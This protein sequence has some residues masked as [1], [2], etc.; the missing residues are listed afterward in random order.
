MRETPRAVEVVAVVASAV[1]K[2]RHAVRSEGSLV[3]AESP[4]GTERMGWVARGRAGLVRNPN[5]EVRS[6]K[7]RLSAPTISIFGRPFPRSLRACVILRS[8]L[9]IIPMHGRLR[10]PLQMGELLAHKTW[11][12]CSVPLVDA[13]YSMYT[14]L[15]HRHA[16]SKVALRKAEQCK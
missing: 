8:S 4:R 15:L 1:K 10:R 5:F 16:D 2:R 3:A 12:I 14:S 11:Y 9:V 13:E 7:W 6:G